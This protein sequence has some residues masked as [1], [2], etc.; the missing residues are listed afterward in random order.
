MRFSSD[1]GPTDPDLGS[2]LGIGLKLFGVPGE[3]MLGEVGGTAD[4]IMQAASRFFVDDAQQMVEFTYAGVVQRNYNA[5]LATQ[6]AT[7]DILNAMTAPRGYVLTPTYWA[8]LPFHLGSETVK[9]TSEERR[10]GKECGSTCR[11]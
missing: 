5:Y 9:S 1:T 6:K 4:L 8:I 3:N 7:T 11:R 2:T 10:V